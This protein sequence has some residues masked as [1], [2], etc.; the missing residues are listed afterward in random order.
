MSQKG[1]REIELK[2]CHST[3]LNMLNMNIKKMY[4]NH[5]NVPESNVFFFF[6]GSNCTCTSIISYYDAQR[7]RD[8]KM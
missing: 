4:E 8:N 5:L 3:T 7:E 1:G 2:L 6:F